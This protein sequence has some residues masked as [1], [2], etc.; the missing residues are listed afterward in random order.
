M[1]FFTYLPLAFMHGMTNVLYDKCIFFTN[2]I[3]SLMIKHIINM[4]RMHHYMSHCV[5]YINYR[6][7]GKDSRINT[8]QP[9]FLY[10]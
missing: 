5:N 10:P 9:L 4:S 8:N 2:S 1:F 6:Q 3:C 7:S